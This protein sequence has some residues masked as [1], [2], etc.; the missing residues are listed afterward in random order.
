[1]RVTEQTK[2]TD[3]ADI[4]KYFKPDTVDALTAAAERC[5]GAMYDLTFAEFWDCSGGNY[6]RLGDLTDPTVLQ[7]YW[8]KRFKAF[9]DEFAESLKKLQLPPTADEKRAG[10]NLLQVSWAEG[11]L[12][13]V[14]QWFKLPSYKAAEQITIGEILIAKRAQYNQDKYRRALS[15]IQIEKLHKK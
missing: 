1:M 8:I 5:H 12:V 15:K 9:F 6:D 3:I 4:E 2:Y 10:N 13:F 11:I 14:Q 7:V